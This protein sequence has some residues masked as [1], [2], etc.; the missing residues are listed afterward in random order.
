MFSRLLRRIAAVVSLALSLAAMS[1]ALALPTPDVTPRLGVFYFGMGM[2]VRQ[3]FPTD[4]GPDCTMP[5]I[6]N[7][8]EEHRGRFTVLSGTYL[9]HG[10]GHQG[11]YPF[12]TGIAR[13]KKQNISFDQPGMSQVLPRIRSV[14]FFGSPPSI[15]RTTTFLAGIIP[16]GPVSRR[17]APRDELGDG[18]E[19]VGRRQALAEGRLRHA[20]TSRAGSGSLG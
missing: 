17:P 18:H 1:S 3:F 13:E 4:V 19:L 7:P 11:T 6:L 14:L 12:A 8:L 10:G 15:E 2:N 16:P 20:G 9:Q 5:R